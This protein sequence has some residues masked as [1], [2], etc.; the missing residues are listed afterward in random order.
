MERIQQY[1]NGQ[2]TTSTIANANGNWQFHEKA[3]DNVNWYKTHYKW[4][5]SQEHKP[6]YQL[7]AVTKSILRICQ[8]FGS[9][10]QPSLRK[11]SY[12]RISTNAK[13]NAQPFK[14]LEYRSQY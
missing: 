6:E 5:W 7:A 3:N 2:I 10:W 13:F 12:E 8:L 11:D 9:G 14:W 1:M 4:A